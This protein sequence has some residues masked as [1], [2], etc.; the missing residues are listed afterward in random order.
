MPM[1]LNANRRILFRK[2][3]KNVISMWDPLISHIIAVTD[4]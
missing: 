4:L 1:F 3:I 2:L